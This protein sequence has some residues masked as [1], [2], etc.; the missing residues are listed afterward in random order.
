MYELFQEGKTGSG[1][2]E[3]GLNKIVQ[4]YSNG[5]VTEEQIEHVFRFVARGMDTLSY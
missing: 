5:A 1:I 3:R 4:K 2:D